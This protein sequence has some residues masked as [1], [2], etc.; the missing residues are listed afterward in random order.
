[1]KYTV[2]VVRLVFGAWFVMSGLRYYQP[3]MPMGR[4]PVAQELMKALVNSD[5]MLLVK[6]VEL[7]VGTMLV[8]DVFV[9]LALLI[10][11]P[12]TLMVAY[13]CLII[14]WPATRPMIGGGAT[15]VAHVFLLFAYL[16]Y[17]RPMLSFKSPLSKSA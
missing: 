8:L 2:L 1:M 6:S 14:E 7:V 10:G 5:I 9:P 15:L 13:V 3:D 16:K 12:V 11:F 4:T 17:Y